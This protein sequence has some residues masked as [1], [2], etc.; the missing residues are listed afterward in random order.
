MSELVCFPT[1][2]V[3]NNNGVR[4][5]VRVRLDMIWKRTRDGW[6]GPSKHSVLCEKYFT[7][8]FYEPDTAIVSSIGLKKLK[9]GYCHCL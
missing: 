7:A 2:T 3:I 9:I 1:H 6:S 8:D 4:S 5:F